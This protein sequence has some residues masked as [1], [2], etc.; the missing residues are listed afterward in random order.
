[1]L[2]RQ[3]EED[4]TFSQNEKKVEYISDVF[5][6]KSFLRADCTLTPPFIHFHP[7][8]FNQTAVSLKVTIELIQRIQSNLCI[9]TTTGVQN[10]LHS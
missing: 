5:D 3:E 9:R 6:L 4:E 1:M 2:R 8:S 10:S 7:Y